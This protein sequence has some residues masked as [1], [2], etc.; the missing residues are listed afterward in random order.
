[1]SLKDSAMRDAPVLAPKRRAAKQAPLRTLASARLE[2]RVT[3]EQKAQLQQAAALSGRSLSDFVITSAQEAA[4]LVLEQHE[5]IRL[6]RA[7][8]LAFVN[9]LLAPKS[10]NAKLQRAAAAYRERMGL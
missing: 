8:Q 2:T 6:S 5:T 9:A 3:I 10:P 4:R 7:G 1:M